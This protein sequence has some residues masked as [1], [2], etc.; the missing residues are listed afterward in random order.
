MRRNGKYNGLVARSTD[1]I[2]V[3]QVYGLIDKFLQ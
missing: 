3:S 2:V 1:Y